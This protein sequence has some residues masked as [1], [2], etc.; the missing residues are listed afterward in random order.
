MTTDTVRDVGSPRH[1]PRA[2]SAHPRARRRDRGGAAVASRSRDGHR[3]RRAVQ[4]RRVEGRGRA[5]RRHPHHP[6]GDR[7]GGAGRRLDGLV[8][9]HGD[10]HLP[11]ERPVRARDPPQALPQRPDRRLGRLGQP[12]GPGRR[13]ARRLPGHRALVLRQRLHALLPAPRRLQGLRR[14]SRPGGG[15]TATRRCGSPTSARSRTRASSTPGTSAA[16]GAR[17]ATTSRS[18]TCSCPR[19]T[20]SRP[21]IPGARHRA[22]EPHARLRSRRLRLCC[23]GA[24]RGPRGHRRVRR[25]GPGQGAA[26]VV[27]AAARPVDRPGPGG[28]GRGGPARRAGAPVRRRRGDVGDRAGRRSRSPSASARTCAWP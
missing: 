22:D 2:R 18:R 13:R 15:P 7:G 6:A 25:A 21:S 8:R 9:G 26:L 4:G 14:R 5:R 1:R 10:Q 28:R 24:G 23:V 19:S 16:C 20:P 17:A 27:R 12:A 11:T 3:H